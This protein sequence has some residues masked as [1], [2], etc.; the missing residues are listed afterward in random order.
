VFRETPII[1]IP[2]QS[3]AILRTADE[4]RENRKYTTKMR[5]EAEGVKVKGSAF[6]CFAPLYTEG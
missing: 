3:S 1:R 6:E 2:R 4:E 5:E